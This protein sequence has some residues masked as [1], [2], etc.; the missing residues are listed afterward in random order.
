MIRHSF[1]ILGFLL[2]LLAASAAVP[3]E[4]SAVICDA[5][6]GEPIAGVVVKALG[7][8]SK[9]IGFASSDSQGRFRVRPNGVADSLSFRC[10]GYENAT[11]PATHDFCKGVTLN[12]AVTQLKDV[13][14]KA[15]DIYAKGDTLVFNVDRFSNADDNAIID[16]IKRLPGITVEDDGTIKYQGK[17]IN[18]FYINGNDF[19]GGQYGLATENISKDDV[20]SVEV[21]ENHQPVKALE[22]IEF[23]EEAGINL[24]LKDDARDSWV[25]VAK[26]ATGMEPLLYDGSLYAMRIASDVQNIFTLRGGNTGWNPANQI[27]EHDFHD[28]F[29][30]DYRE[31]LWPEY[32]SADIVSAPLSEKRTRD[33]LSWIANAI[34]AWKRGDNSMR[35]KLNYVADRLDYESSQHTGYFSPSIADFV[36]RDNL[37]SRQHDLSAQFNSEINRRGLYLKDKLTVDASWRNSESAVT[38]TTDLN[39]NVRRRSI[40]AVNDIKL[41]K[42][43]DKRLFELVS[44]N[45]FLHSPDR[46][47]ISGTGDAEQYLGI[48]DLRSTTATQFGKLTRSWK[49]YL[50]GGIDLNYHRINSRLQGLVA[51]DNA[52]VG[53]AFLSDV[54]ATPKVD[55]NR[56]NRRI[57]MSMP[58][59]WLHHSLNGH[60]DYLNISPRLSVWKNTSA[61]SEFY[62]SVAWRLTSPQAYMNLPAAILADYR[63]LFAGTDDAGGYSRDFATTL[64]YRYRNP[65]NA[66]FF[67]AS[68]SCNLSRSALMCNQLFIADIIVSTYSQRLSHSSSWWL[69]GG[70]SKGLGHGHF[71]AGCDVSASVS[72]ASSM[73]DNTVYPYRQLTISARPYLRG[74][75]LRCLSLNYEADYSF[76]RMAVENQHTACHSFR[77][78]VRATFTPADALHLSIGA[79][80]FLTRFPEGNTG[81]LVLLDASAVWQLNGKTRLSLTADNLLNRRRYEYVTYGT[82][83]R[84]E[85]TFRI[86]PRNILASI[87]YRF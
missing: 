26:A 42:R 5:T 67:N 59:K 18:K 71:V 4:F 75:L 11:L 55:Y 24:T 25:G 76:A 52:G 21:M 37:R 79:E 87:Q 74:S 34:S 46:L 50:S 69:N 86:R 7:R 16:V 3:E 65:L 2:G 61:R 10:M 44:R 35:L 23:P 33:N 70:I 80:H 17:P 58:V 57:S 66:L 15:P 39:Q 31:S 43:S 49:F 73:R 54:H 68:A 36:R 60:R 41:V 62:G 12:P 83:S 85:H 13:I 77:Q 40:S 30:A 82:L 56:S 84:T 48:T 8:D 72:S 63:N 1:F 64:S 78:N 38:G 45:S 28:M 27:T 19:I 29:P 53:N 9:T 6:S 47:R 81:N 20:K 22:G 14:I 32:I 51:F